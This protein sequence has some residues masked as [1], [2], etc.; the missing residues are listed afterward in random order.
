MTLVLSLSIN[1]KKP[2]RELDKGL[3]YIANISIST[4]IVDSIIVI[5]YRR[6]EGLLINNKINI[7]SNS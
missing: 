3:I 2:S 5:R 1:V 7:I 6:K 4:I